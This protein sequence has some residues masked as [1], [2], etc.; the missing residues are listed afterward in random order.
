M[1]S[2]V[3]VVAF[4]PAL[5]MAQTPFRE[6]G[7]G[8][9]TPISVDIAGCVVEPCQLIRGT[10]SLN[11]FIFTS[12]KKVFDF[13]LFQGPYSNSAFPAISTN[14]IRPSVRAIILGIG[15]EYRK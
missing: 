6:C 10:D 3:L 8:L 1:L 14:T 4:L 13:F 7:N 12:G 9:P 15:I 11:R 2:Y 5:I